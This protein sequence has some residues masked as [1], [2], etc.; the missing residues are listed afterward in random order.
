MK[1]ARFATEEITPRRNSHGA[2]PPHDF[3]PREMLKKGRDLLIA[4]RAFAR[5]DR[6]RSW[7]VVVSTFVLMIGTLTASALLTNVW[8]RTILSVVG[9]LLMVR[10]FITYHDYMHGAIL[11]S[12]RTA[13]ALFHV[14]GLF[15]LTPARSWK[16]SHNHHHGAVGQISFIAPGAFPIV[17]TRMWKSAS[18]GAKFRYRLTR[19]PLIIL[20]G[21]VTIFFFSVTLE[22]LLR[23]P[24]HHWDSAISL[25]CHGSLVASLWMFGGFDDAFFAVLL[26]MTLSSTLG[27]YLFFAQH[28]FAGMIVLRP[29][30]WSI[31]RAALVTSSYMRLNRMMHWFTGN[32]GYHHVHHLNVRIPFYRL[33][34]AMAAIPT[35]QTPIT[36][37]LSLR[38]VIACFRSSLWDEEQQRMVPYREA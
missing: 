20:F 35:L 24:K 6:A 5:E 19:H 29:D 22:P 7:R 15:S 23:N 18:S 33:R 14:Y 37:S 16:R 1:N 21:Y 8:L 9:A 2:S 3:G 26:P 32:I 17:T 27:S 36:T 25:L 38:D 31:Y 34:E 11:R 12:S 28:S 4:T 30:Q 10:T 13:S